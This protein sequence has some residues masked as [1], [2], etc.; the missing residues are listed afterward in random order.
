NNNNLVRT[1]HQDN[2]GNP[3]LSGLPP[4]TY[5]LINPQNGSSTTVT[6]PPGTNGGNSTFNPGST[7]NNSIYLFPNPAINVVKFNVNSG[8]DQ[9]A[10]VT[11]VNASGKTIYHEIKMI[12]TG[13]NALDIDI[14]GFPAG[15]Y[16][17]I[18]TISGK[19]TM[20]GRLVRKISADY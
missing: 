16:F 1:I 8:S 4:G 12:T 13:D 7:A 2:S 10:D 19:Q 18:V 9:Q 14:S 5:N 20:T 15:E 17:V 6:I 11:V 3:N